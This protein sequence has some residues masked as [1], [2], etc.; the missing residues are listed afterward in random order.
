LGDWG[1]VQRGREKREERITKGVK[2][3]RG[4]GRRGGHLGGTVLGEGVPR[5]GVKETEEGIDENAL[6]VKVKV[7]LLV[8]LVGGRLPLEDIIK[9]PEFLGRREMGV[10]HVLLKEG[11]I[12]PRG[13]NKNGL[14]VSLEYYFVHM[15]P[16]GLHG[17]G[18]NMGTYKREPIVDH[19]TTTTPSGITMPGNIYD[20][21][22]NIIILQSIPF[23]LLIFEANFG[24]SVSISIWSRGRKRHKRDRL[25]GGFIIGIG[26][27]NVVT[28]RITTHSGK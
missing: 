11:E 21:S 19:N 12:H 13:G 26:N 25:R 17:V 3:V 27:D 15:G 20:G 16:I 10:P 7:P 9:Y 24:F 28:G 23:I 22:I 5:S 14:V 8:R 2:G 1:R 6:M 18:I 4:M